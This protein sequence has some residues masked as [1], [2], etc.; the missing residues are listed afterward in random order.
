MADKKT[1][2]TTPASS[3]PKPAAEEELEFQIAA[4]LTLYANPLRCL[5]VGKKSSE[6]EKNT[7]SHSAPKKAPQSEDEKETSGGEIIAADLTKYGSPLD[8]K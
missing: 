1:T 8:D 3:Q 7:T 5:S 2:E 4:D 6:S